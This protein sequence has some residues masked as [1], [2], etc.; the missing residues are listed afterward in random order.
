[1]KRFQVKDTKN[2]YCARYYGLPKEI[3]KTDFE[4]WVSDNEKEHN[5]DGPAVMVDFGNGIIKLTIDK[6][7]PHIFA[8][9]SGV[10]FSKESIESS[11]Q[12][13][14]NNYAILFAYYNHLLSPEELNE[15]LKSYLYKS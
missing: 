13:I 14:T 1:M 5:D 4:I 3:T 7:C 8:K 2:H 12:F 15:K 10:E 9:T 6:D 11:K